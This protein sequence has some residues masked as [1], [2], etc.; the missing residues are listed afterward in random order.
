M[1][2]SIH[3]LHSGDSSSIERLRD[4]ARTLSRMPVTMATAIEVIGFD[5]LQPTLMAAASS[6]AAEFGVVAALR[7]DPVLAVRFERR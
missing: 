6:V 5:D 3:R 1:T 4:A 7:T 2:A